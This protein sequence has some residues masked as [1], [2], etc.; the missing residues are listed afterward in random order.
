VEYIHLG[1][2]I[3]NDQH[4]RMEPLVTEVVR[5]TME[6]QPVLV[7]VDS[8][9]ALRDFAEDR[10]L[11]LALLRYIELS[12]AAGRA[13]NIVKMRNSNHHKDL[14]QF[15]IGEHGPTI[16]DKLEGVTGVLGW[17]VLRAANAIL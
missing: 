16:G 17:S 5:K 3:R 1:D 2:L 7:V 11:R 10:E 8:A 13:V 6:E 12:S 15:E 4:G 14:Y 9:N